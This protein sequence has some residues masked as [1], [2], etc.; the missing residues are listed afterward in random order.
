MDISLLSLLNE[1]CQHKQISPNYSVIATGGLA[2]API[3]KIQLDVGDYTFVSTAS[4]KKLAKQICAKKAI[5]ELKI[6]LFFKE[7][8]EKPRYKITEIL[9]PLDDIWNNNC[10]K[11]VITLRRVLKGEEVSK[12]IEL[13]LVELIEER[14]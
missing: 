7:L 1:Y 2:H 13:R 10:E 9:T 4:S 6:E 14:I 8:N 3:F 11:V 5:E 12:T